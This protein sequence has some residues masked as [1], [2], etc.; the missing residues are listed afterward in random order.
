MRSNTASTPYIEAVLPRQTQAEFHET[1]TGL[2]ADLVRQI[3][4]IEGPIHS[5]E[6]IVRLRTIYGLQRSGPESNL[7][8]NARSPRPIQSGTLLREGNILSISGTSPKV[9][10]RRQVSNPGLRKPELLLLQEIQTAIL[11]LVTESFGAT[12]DEIV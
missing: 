12:Q 8:R 6:V 3:V 1:P 11:E 10:D 7:Q 5:E 2:L 4:R 9:R